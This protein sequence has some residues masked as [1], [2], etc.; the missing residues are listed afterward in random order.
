MKKITE[1]EA[2]N[3]AEENKQNGCV[4]EYIGVEDVP[5]KHAAQEYKV[6]PD[7]LKNKKVYSFHELDKYGAAS[8]QYYIDFEGNVYRDTL[9][10]NNQCVKIK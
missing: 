5:Y 2:K 7:E 9:P 3:L 4:I 1:I 10:I 6:F 8:S